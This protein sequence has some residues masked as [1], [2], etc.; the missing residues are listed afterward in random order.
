MNGAEARQLYLESTDS[1]KRFLDIAIDSPEG[2]PLREEM[3]LA[4][5]EA[6]EAFADNDDAID[7]LY[8]ADMREL[9]RG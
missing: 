9:E 2:S 8:D 1:A 6:L 4:A 7:A 3:R 5:I